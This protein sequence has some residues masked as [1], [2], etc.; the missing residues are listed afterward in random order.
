MLAAGEF[1]SLPERIALVKR[2]SLWG[3]SLAFPPW[4]QLLQASLISILGE[5]IMSRIQFRV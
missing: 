4:L 1:S 5:I 3:F 2:R